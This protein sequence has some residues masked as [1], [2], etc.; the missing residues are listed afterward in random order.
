MINLDN[1]NNYVIYNRQQFTKHP[2][3]PP[4]PEKRR[5]KKFMKLLSKSSVDVSYYLPSRYGA[6]KY[7]AFIKIKLLFATSI[8]HREAPRHH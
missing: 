5:K 6:N 4:P 2:S 8:S 1:Y 3:P 7:K